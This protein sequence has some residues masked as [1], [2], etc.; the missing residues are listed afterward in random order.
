MSESTFEAHEECPSCGSKDNLA[1]YS[2]GHGYCFGCN[3]REAPPAGEEGADKEPADKSMSV[4]AGIIPGSFSS[5]PKRKITAETCRFLSYQVGEMGGQKVQLANHLDENGLI[6]AQKVRTADKQFRIIGDSSKCSLWGMH[7][8]KGFKRDVL[9]ITE[10]EVDALSVHQVSGGMWATVSLPNGAQSAKKAVLQQLKWVEEFRKVV[11]AFDMDEPGRKAAQE[12]A[13]VL[14]PGKAAILELPVKDANEMLQADRGGELLKAVLSVKPWKPSGLV[15][16]ADLKAKVLEKRTVGLPFWDERL[17]ELTYGRRTGEIYM[18]GAGT[19]VGKTDWFCQSI[20]FDLNV[21]NEKVAVFFLEQ[22]PVE[23]ITRI[24]GKAAGKLFHVPDDSWTEE[25]LVSEVDR[26]DSDRLHLYDHFGECDWKAIAA[27]IR[28]LYQVEGIKIFYLDHLTA[29][30]AAEEDEKKG[31]EQ[32]MAQ[33]GQLVKQIPIMIMCVS[34][35]ATPEGKPHEEGGRVQIRHFKGSRAIGF[36]S[37]FMFGLE[38]NQQAEDPVEAS[39]TTFRVLKDRYTGRSTGKTLPLSYDSLH[40]R[41][42]PKAATP[43]PFAGAPL[44]TDF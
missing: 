39:Q 7:A 41:L 28:Y 8:W 3:Y 29:L 15:T 33:M 25:E 19:G 22:E 30:A 20:E 37:H 12:C 2:D 5:L 6:V 23:T 4:P 21:L 14:S 34:H 18:F 31:L 36:W 17:T 40:G 10:G 9:V 44:N 27:N 26:L 35:L 32:I 38:R 43:S 42:L 24:A 1:R 16:V 11:L 13:G